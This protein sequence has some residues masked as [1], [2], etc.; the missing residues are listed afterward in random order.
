M[1]EE[2]QPDTS[3]PRGLQALPKW[4]TYAIATAGVVLLLVIALG[5]GNTYYYQV[6]PHVLSQPSNGAQNQDSN[7]DQEKYYLPFDQAL[8]SSHISFDN[9]CDANAAGVSL[10]SDDRVSQAAAEEIEKKACDTL[11]S[12]GV[13]ALQHVIEIPDAVY[14]QAGGYEG[15]GSL[16]IGGKVILFEFILGL[17]DTHT[18]ILSENELEIPRNLS[19]VSAMSFATTTRG[20]SI[21][22]ELLTI[23]GLDG[24]GKQIAQYRTSHDCKGCGTNFEVL[25]SKNSDGTFSQWMNVSQSDW[26]TKLSKSAAVSFWL[27]YNGYSASVGTPSRDYA[28]E[29]GTVSPLYH[30]A[31]CGLE[32]SFSDLEFNGAGITLDIN[33]GL[34]PYMHLTTPQEGYV[35]EQWGKVLKDITMSQFTNMVQTTKAYNSSAHVEMLTIGDYS[36]KH[37]GPITL[38]RTCQYNDKTVV[39]T[40]DMYQVKKGGA[41][42]TFTDT[43]DPT[44]DAARTP[45]DIQKVITQVLNTM[46]ITGQ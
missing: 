27:P 45:T 4:V 34:E 26:D 36:V 39:I 37:V 43:H 5:L 14:N 28:M 44:N 35:P 8:A 24:N 19:A 21:P 41:I 33:F 15:L 16:T 13:S 7:S 29:V 1:P 12:G 31:S 40:A 3:T 32:D 46:T 18:Y 10:T 20:S 23:Q 6:Y 17:S 9:W 42:V 2:N 11:K 38:D 22:P 30:E 25:L